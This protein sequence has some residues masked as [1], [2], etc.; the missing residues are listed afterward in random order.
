MKKIWIAMT[1]V[2]SCSAGFLLHLHA[3]EELSPK[4]PTPRLPTYYGMLAVSDTQREQLYNILNNYD[5]QIEELQK[6]VKAL[7]NERDNKMEALLSP[8]Q[9]LRL[10]ELKDEARKRSKKPLSEQSDPPAAVQE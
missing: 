8:G 1:F 9:R 7:L 4:N 5:Q 2:A 10:K 6:K 3:Q